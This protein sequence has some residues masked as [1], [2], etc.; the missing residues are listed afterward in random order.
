MLQNI[1][2]YIYIHTSMSTHRIMARTD[3]LLTTH[4]KSQRSI[5]KQTQ[6]APPY[7]SLE[8]IRIKVRVIVRDGCTQT[9]ISGTSLD[10]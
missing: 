9:A 4:R 7:S 8:R 3:C 1:I 6:L 10:E 5:R 2:V